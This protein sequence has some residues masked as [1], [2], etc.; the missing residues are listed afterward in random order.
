LGSLVVSK[1][2][3]IIGEHVFY[4]C[5]EMTIYTDDVATDNKWSDKFNSSFR[6]VI[7]G[8]TLSEDKTYVVSVTITENTISNKMVKNG[9]AAPEREGYD[10]AGWA[11]Q[12]NGAPVYAAADIDKAAIGTTLYAVWTEAVDN[13]ENIE[14]AEI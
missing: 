8:C 11:T 10:F 3:E 7:W 12:E 2:I 5:N 9:I 1:D 4:G 6:P 14:N 13:N